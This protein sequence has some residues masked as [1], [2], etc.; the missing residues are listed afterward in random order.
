MSGSVRTDDKDLWICLERDVDKKYSWICNA[1][2]R[3]R[4]IGHYEYLKNEINS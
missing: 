4:G 1:R 3:S 2:L